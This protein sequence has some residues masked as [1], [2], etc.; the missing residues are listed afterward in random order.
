[1]RREVKGGL[2]RPPL[3]SLSI[4]SSFKITCR[5]IPI[6]SEVK[7]TGRR[8]ATR[9]HSN[10]ALDNPEKML[11]QRGCRREV[12]T[13]TRTVRKVWQATKGRS[14]LPFL[15]HYVA[16]GATTPAVPKP[17]F[18]WAYTADGQ[19][20]NKTAFCWR[21]IQAT[22]RHLSEKIIK[23]HGMWQRSGRREGTGENVRTL[24]GVW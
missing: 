11:L 13:R 7:R 2:G 12:S 10:S 24:R 14:L 22:K 17:L 5:D 20:R 19:I 3:L 8:I 21:V 23:R 4:R 15:S 16:P 6:I 1:M 9:R 18:Y